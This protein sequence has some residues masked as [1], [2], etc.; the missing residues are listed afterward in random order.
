MLIFRDVS[1]NLAGRNVWAS[2]ASFGL[3]NW[4]LASVAI[5][6]LDATVYSILLMAEILHQLIGG[7]SHYL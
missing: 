1:L 2:L 3:A 4:H 6:I 7:L 5:S